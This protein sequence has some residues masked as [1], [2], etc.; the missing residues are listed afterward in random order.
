MRDGVRLESPRELLRCPAHEVAFANGEEAGRETGL[1]MAIG[2]GQ[3]GSFFHA[4]RAG[5][6]K[7]HGHDAEGQF[8][9]DTGGRAE[10]ESGIK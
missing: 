6:E 7:G 5:I 3:K 9:F 8:H 1:H 2:G 10:I 4:V